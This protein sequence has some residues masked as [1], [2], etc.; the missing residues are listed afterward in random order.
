MT[1]RREL[2]KE[3][4]LPKRYGLAE[5]ALQAS[6]LYAVRC[7]LYAVSFSDT[8][9]DFIG[10]PWPTATRPPL[11]TPLTALEELCCWQHYTNWRKLPPLRNAQPTLKHLG[12]VSGGLHDSMAGNHLE[13]LLHC[14]SS[15]VHLIACSMLST[16]PSPDKC[17]Q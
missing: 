15:G 10:P 16:C 13:Y 1:R 7:T 14:N 12:I 6:T 17:E 5:N 3:Q 2:I 11:T 4:L 8:V 9:E